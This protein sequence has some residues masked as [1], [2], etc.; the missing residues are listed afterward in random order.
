MGKKTNLKPMK[1]IHFFFVL[2]FV[3]LLVFP[4][5]DKYRVPKDFPDADEMA[6]IIAELHIVES[7]MN[8]GTSYANTPEKNNPGYY[9][10]ILE[11]HGLTSEK[12]DTIR[13][14]YV[15]NPEIYQYVYN[16]AIV[17]LSKREAEI[18]VAV[19]YQREQE[20]LKQA[21]LRKRPSNLWLNESRIA[22]AT[23]DTID[24]RLP[25]KFATDSLD[26]SGTLRLKAFY[27]FLLEDASLSPRLML[28]VLYNDS[29]ADTVYLKIP[30]SFHKKGAELDLNL[31]KDFKALEVY[32][33][34][35]LQD[36]A[37]S[38]SVEI[39]NISLLVLRDSLIESEPTEAMSKKRTLQN[40][41]E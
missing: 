14:W 25:F 13:K 10:F 4:G 2:G 24:K 28:S 16:Q 6:E 39:E 35:L 37:Y 21:E 41:R 8:F 1:G 32:G 19:E 15:D 22:L 11:K 36:T 18:S 40:T 30:H 34:L 3:S 27:K 17:I 33:Y 12:F 31:K 38:S 26:L 23:T 9:R 29:T 5:C 7:S 20:K